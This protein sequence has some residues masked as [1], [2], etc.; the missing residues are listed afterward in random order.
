VRIP[1]LQSLGVLPFWQ[2][3]SSRVPLSPTRSAADSWT[4]ATPHFCTLT[5]PWQARFFRMQEIGKLVV[6]IGGL[7]VVVGVI[8]WRFPSLFGWVG[9]LPG[10]ISVQ[11]G[12]FSFYFPVVTCILISIVVTLVSWLFRR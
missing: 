2:G 1:I 4:P 7:L 5:C 6:M 3:G 10:D 9:R 8:L 11:K 12:N